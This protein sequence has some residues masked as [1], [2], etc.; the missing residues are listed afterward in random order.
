MHPF[1]Q[2]AF[3]LTAAVFWKVAAGVGPRWMEAGCILLVGV[4]NWTS[5]MI[6]SSYV[7]TSST[8]EL[9]LYSINTSTAAS[10]SHQILSRCISLPSS[11]PMYMLAVQYLALPCTPFDSVLSPQLPSIAD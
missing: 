4:P 9:P 1:I 5:C 3:G 7:A 2:L 8:A 11:S 10:L 6:L